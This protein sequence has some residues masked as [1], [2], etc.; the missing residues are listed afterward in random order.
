MDRDLIP[1]SPLEKMLAKCGSVSEVREAIAEHPPL[2][3]AMLES[4]RSCHK[5]I[6]ERLR[7][8]QYSNRNLQ[9]LEPATAE[10]IASIELVLKG[11]D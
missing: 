11:I 3:E 1:K 9:V 5:T 4:T 7:R 10:E 6:V 8:A 2:R